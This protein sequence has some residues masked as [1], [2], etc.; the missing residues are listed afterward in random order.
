MFEGSQV[1]S[2][3][4]GPKSKIYGFR[5]SL[6]WEHLGKALFERQ[7]WD[8]SL[9]DR[10]WDPECIRLVQKEAKQNWETF[11]AEGKPQHVKGHLMRFP[12]HVNDD[13][14][15]TH[16][17]GHTYIPDFPKSLIFGCKTMIPN[18]ITT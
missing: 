13:G 11:I 16:L 14:T 10:P 18:F 1:S 3:G 15:I 2:V 9:F 8:R 6:W 5:M 12:Y 17:E 7:D 4:H